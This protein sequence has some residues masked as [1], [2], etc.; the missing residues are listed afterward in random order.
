[1]AD[2]RGPGQR[3]DRR[4]LPPAHRP[5]RRP[6]GRL[7]RR[8]R[9]HQVH[10]H[11]RVQRRPH[12]SGAARA[13]RGERRPT[14]TAEARFGQDW[15]ERAW[16]PR[17]GTMYLQVGIGSGNTAGHVQR[18]PRP[19]AAAR[20][21]RHARRPRE[22]VPALSPRVPR[23]RP[24]DTAAA[25]PR[26]ADGRGVRARGPGRRG[27]RSGARPAGARDRGIDLPPREDGQ[28]DRGRR[29]HGAAP[30]LLPGVVLARRPGVGRRRARA[31]RAGARRS[32]RRRVAARRRTLGR[33]VPRAR[34]GPRHPE[35][36]RH[37]GGRAR[38]PGPGDARGAV[39]E[40]P[41]HG[42]DPAGRRPPVA[43]GHGHRAR[44]RDPFAAGAVY[45][46]FDV[47]AHTFGLL[48]TE[49]LYEE[50]TGQTNFAAF[51]TRQ[52]DWAFGA[53]PGAP[54]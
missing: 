4:P 10:A 39:G 30:R 28:G 37:V 17:T 31:G 20:G 5:P 13:G 41:R 18:R 29:R 6:L 48:A 27:R 53:N 22:P 40:R 9:L 7:V 3:R 45:D 11:D 33:R 12:V 51:A 16:D 23:Q 47:A 38:G 54:R 52:R 42:R 34:G 2:L 19:L 26:R 46:D 49:R 1:M 36:L 24:G 21:G 14:S 50:L 32:A 15:L 8:R 44:R 25:E 35:S 43:A